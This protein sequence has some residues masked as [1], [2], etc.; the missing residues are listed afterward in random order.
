M[1]CEAPDSRQLAVLSYNSIGYELF[2]L[3][4]KLYIKRLFNTFI[5]VN[6]YIFQ[7]NY[8]SSKFINVADGWLYFIVDSSSDRLYK[9]KNDGTK[10]QMVEKLER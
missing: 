5:N 8:E 2:Y 7:V 9:M 4:I 10:I 6:I 3:L 1:L